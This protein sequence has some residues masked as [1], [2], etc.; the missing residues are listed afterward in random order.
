MEQLKQF[1]RENNVAITIERYP[2]NEIK[3]HGEVLNVAKVYSKVQSVLA[4]LYKQNE[5]A[6]RLLEAVEWQHKNSD[7]V[8]T[9]YNA[10]LNFNIE[11]AYELD[12]KGVFVNPD[13]KDFKV[14]FA[15]KMEHC[16]GKVT[17]VQQLDKSSQGKI[18]EQFQCAVYLFC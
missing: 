4:N 17:P 13:Q 5:Q 3:L 8:F 18:P 11:K 15:T 6:E 7:G 10:L 9:S 16:N 2:M 12:Q 1:S 14:D